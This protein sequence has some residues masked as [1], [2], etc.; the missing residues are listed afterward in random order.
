ME[1]KQENKDK[2]GRREKRFF[3]RD[4]T[5]HQQ[6]GVSVT[7]YTPKHTIRRKFFNN[8]LKELNTVQGFLKHPEGKEY[9]IRL[10]DKR[11]RGKDFKMLGSS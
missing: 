11:G 4:I 5:A 8:K 3:L 6:K 9:T 1:V 7:I 10:E 2:V